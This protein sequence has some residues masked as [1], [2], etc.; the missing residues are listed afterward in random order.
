[1]D[2]PSDPAN[3][4]L[5]H[6]SVESSEMMNIYTGNVLTDELGIAVVTLPKWFE[7]L[8]TD[9]RFQLTVI[10]RKAQAWI[11]QEVQDG[12]FIIASDATHVKVSWQIT[13]VRQDPYAKA[14]PLVVEQ[15]KDERERGFYLTPELYGQP[16]EKQMEWGRHPEQMRRMKAEREAQKNKPVASGSPTFASEQPA[17][18]VNRPVTPVRIL[19]PGKSKKQ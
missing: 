3:K 5:V 16:E 10:G 19:T 6:S 15:E 14:H 18:A 2:H 12:R 4:Y 9:F 7:V 1:M 17:S 13:S 8:N 11:S